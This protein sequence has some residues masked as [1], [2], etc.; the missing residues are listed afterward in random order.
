MKKLYVYLRDLTGLTLGLL[1]PLLV[2]AGPTGYWETDNVW[3]IVLGLFYGLTVIVAGAMLVY[4][5]FE[6]YWDG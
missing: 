2:F 1:S 3:V 4:L 6:R 5:I